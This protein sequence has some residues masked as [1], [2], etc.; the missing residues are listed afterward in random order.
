M[1]KYRTSAWHYANPIEK[2]E[3]TRETDKCVFYMDRNVETKALKSSDCDNYFDTFDQAKQYLID[4]V[5][6]KVNNCIENLEYAKHLL[7]NVEKLEEGE[8]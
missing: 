2:I 5:Q 6:S 8:V 1:I 7:D 4:Q 3:C